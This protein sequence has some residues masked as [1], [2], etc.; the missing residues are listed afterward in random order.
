[1]QHKNLT[2][3]I[4]DSLTNTS[5]DNQSSIIYWANLYFN[6]NVVNSPTHTTRAK[7][8]DIDKFLHF[9]QSSLHSDN[10][11]LWAPSV[12]KGFLKYLQNQKSSKT[13]QPYIATTIN[14]ILATIRHFAN[15][16]KKQITLPS[17]NPFTGVKLIQ[18]EEPAWNGLTENEIMRLKGAC[19]NRLNACNKKYQNPVLET[20]VFY[21]LLM[22]GLRE[23]ELV[24]LNVKQYYNR[25]FHEVKRKGNK[26]TKKIPLP[27]EAREYLDQYLTSRPNLQDNDPLLLSRYSN[28]ILTRDIARICQRIARQA[29]VYLPKHQELTLSPHML[30]H[31]FL[32]R[33]AD[34]HG[35]HV[36]QDLSGNISMK[37]IFRY[38]KPNHNEKLDIVEALYQEY[39]SS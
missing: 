20:A 4:H 30:R 2:I 23:S 36:A 7:K 19:D 6:I 31:T 27:K 11:S 1:M 5:S 12:T 34:K 28:R 39:V 24:S 10:I 32:K 13:N 9:F 14:R 26:I 22:T 15:W 21:I 37:E 29:S 17:G 8:N 38:T 16:L 35:I 25:G 18:V 33:I 3:F